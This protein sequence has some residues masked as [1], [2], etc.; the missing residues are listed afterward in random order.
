MEQ[1]VVNLLTN[2]MKYGRGKLIVIQIKKTKFEAE[3]IFKDNGIG[4]EKENL[5][6]IFN[7]FERAVSGQ[8][9]SGL[10]L[11]LYISR[12]I[13]EDHGGTISV[14]SVVGKGSTFKVK[15]PRNNSVLA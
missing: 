2:A 6:R 12:K 5:E 7:S 15:I 10:G 11:G 1:V 3:L 9:F 4:I 13:I 14:E 8:K